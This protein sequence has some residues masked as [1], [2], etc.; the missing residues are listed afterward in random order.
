MILVVLFA[1]SILLGPV[2]FLIMILALFVLGT[3]ELF[4]L[5]SKDGLRPC[6]LH[7]ASG[8]AIIIIIFAGLHGHA[9]PLWLVVPALLWIGG[10]FIQGSEFAASLF[11]FWFSIPLASF[12]ALGWVL[13]G[14]TY[15]PLIPILVIALVWINDIFAYL[16]GSLAGKHPMTPRLSPGKT[17]EGFAG[18]V[19]FTLLAGW[20]LYRFTGTFSAAAWIISGG[21]ISAFAVLGDLFESGLKRRY[22]V[23]DTGNLLPGHGGILD[24]FDSLMFVA[25]AILIVLVILNLFL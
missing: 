16:T 10:I 1:G 24:R 18:G 4:R 8:A 2:P 3:A 19:L 15:R 6:G 7:A 14:A 23:K 11:L 20:F 9:N 5:F 25:P 22:K 13:G 12:I 21:V 17:W